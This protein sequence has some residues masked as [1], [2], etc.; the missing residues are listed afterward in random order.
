V[1]H[2]VLVVSS[3]QI[4]VPLS[5]KLWVNRHWVG[6]DDR[7]LVLGAVE[8]RARP[9]F[10]KARA[11]HIEVS[12]LRAVVHDVSCRRRLAA[13]ITKPFPSRGIYNFGI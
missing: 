5:F 3:A 6:K 12:T 13:N 11:T 8:K 7:V 1:I 10:L 9:S 4:A 2:D